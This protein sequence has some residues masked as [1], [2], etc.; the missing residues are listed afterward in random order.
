[1][2]DTEQ[3][4]KAKVAIEVNPENNY[5]KFADLLELILITTIQIVGVQLDLNAKF[6]INPYR[7]EIDKVEDLKERMLGKNIDILMMMMI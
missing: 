4:A 5:A 1:M 3:M 7:G 6:N 2:F